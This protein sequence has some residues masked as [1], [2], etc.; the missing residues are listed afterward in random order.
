[1]GVW[2]CSW[3]FTL[4]LVEFYWGTLCV[5]LSWVNSWD[6]LEIAC[7]MLDFWKRSQN[8]R[9]RRI[10]RSVWGDEMQRVLIKTAVESKCLA[11]DMQIDSEGAHSTV[12]SP[13][14]NVTNSLHKFV[15]FIYRVQSRTV[16][17][18]FELY[19]SKFQYL[20]ESLDLSNVNPFTHGSRDRLL[21]SFKPSKTTID[22][23]IPYVQF[24][25]QWI[26]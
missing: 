17:W 24:N 3:G 7:S 21:R 10:Y 11:D 6:V 18:D 5:K 23:A 13:L 26:L 4:C 20:K 8:A 25:S 16:I 22:S 15:Y 1:M 14:R 9:G 12:F 2:W 19:C